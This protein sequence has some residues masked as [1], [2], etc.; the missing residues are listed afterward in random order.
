MFS[1]LYLVCFDMDYQNGSH[2]VEKKKHR[3]VIKI[4]III[5]QKYCITAPFI[6][7][8]YK[9]VNTFRLVSSIQTL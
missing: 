7:N 8:S 5:I 3:T 1:R 4:P 2:S 9:N 6:M